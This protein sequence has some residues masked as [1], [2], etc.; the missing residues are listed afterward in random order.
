VGESL[1]GKLQV[2]DAKN[3]EWRT[4]RVKKDPACGV[5]AKKG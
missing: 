2:L 1:S 5:C 4:V 3:A